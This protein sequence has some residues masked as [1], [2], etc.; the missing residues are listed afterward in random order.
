PKMY[1]HYR[2][3]AD[4]NL[5]GVEFKTGQR[6]GEVFQR[7]WLSV[8]VGEKM[9]VRVCSESKNRRWAGAAFQLDPTSFQGKGSEDWNSIQMAIDDKATLAA[10]HFDRAG[11]PSQIIDTRIVDETELD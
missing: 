7:G 4:E 5:C 2:A 1:A 10:S 3:R 8:I 9:L 11:A 6:L